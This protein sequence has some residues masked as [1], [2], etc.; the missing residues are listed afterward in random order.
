MICVLWL[1]LWL[2]EKYVKRKPY[3]QGWL[4]I[5]LV[6]FMMCLFLIIQG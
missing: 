5:H 4:D 2:G 3:E 6:G 1:W